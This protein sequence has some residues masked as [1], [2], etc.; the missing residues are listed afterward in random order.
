[1]KETVDIYILDTS[2]LLA[3]IEAEAGAREGSHADTRPFK[4]RNP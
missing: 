2:A 4:F 1:M 3:F